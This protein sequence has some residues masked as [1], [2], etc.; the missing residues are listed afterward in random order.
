MVL[1]RMLRVAGAMGSAR[2][3]KTVSCSL[4]SHKK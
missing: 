4:E 2:E 1:L 3:A